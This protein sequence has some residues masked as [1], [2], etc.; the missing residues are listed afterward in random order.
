MTTITHHMHHIGSFQ[1]VGIFTPDHICSVLLVLSF[2][3]HYIYSIVAIVLLY[4]E[5]RVFHGV[6]GIDCVGATIIG[7]IDCIS[8]KY[9]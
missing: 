9:S 7:A 6:V 8:W 2:D 4:I 5:F 1:N 3:L